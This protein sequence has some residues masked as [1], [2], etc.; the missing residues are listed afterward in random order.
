MI[1]GLKELSGEVI[2]KED[3]KSKQRFFETYYI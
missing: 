3:C 1:N 2:V